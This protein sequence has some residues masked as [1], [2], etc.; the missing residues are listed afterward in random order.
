MVRRASPGSRG[1]QAGAKAAPRKLREGT[2]EPEG[3]DPLRRHPLREPYAARSGAAPETVGTP[4]TVTRRP[5]AKRRAGRRK[6]A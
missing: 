3:K 4:E 1:Y 6:G 5:A 2:L